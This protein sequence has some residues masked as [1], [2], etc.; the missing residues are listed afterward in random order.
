MNKELLAQLRKLFAFDEKTLPD[1]ITPEDL[2]KLIE[3]QK[4]NFVSPEDFKKLQQTLSAKDIL[5]K[6]FKKKLEQK[7]QTQPPSALEKSLAEMQ[8]TI[9]SLTDRIADMHAAKERES[10]SQ[11]YP[12]IHPDMLL[13]LPAEQREKYAQEQRD[14]ARKMYSDSNA[15]HQPLYKTVADVDV[16]IEK[17]K[18][19]KTMSGIQK[20]TQVMQLNRVKGALS[21][22]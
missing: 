16:A 15:F 9:K 3:N 13:A 5:V 22:N 1:S 2:G 21:S 8:D 10:L 7:D 11:Q 14:I 6:D 19:D 20:A 18:S 12:D 4:G 17:I